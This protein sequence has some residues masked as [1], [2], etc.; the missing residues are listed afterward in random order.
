MERDENFDI[1]PDQVKLSDAKD[2]ERVIEETV[3]LMQ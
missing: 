1:T 2:R 3:A